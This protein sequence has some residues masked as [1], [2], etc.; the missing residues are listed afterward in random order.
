MI[1]MTVDSYSVL[2]T[3]SFREVR[4]IWVRKQKVLIGAAMATDLR[5]REHITGHRQQICY[6]N[7]LYLNYETPCI[8]FTYSGSSIYPT[9]F[10]FYF[11]KTCLGR[12]RREQD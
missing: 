10:Y 5:S 3:E 4:T 11:S 6:N 2:D 9:L 7:K 12:Q 8:A 1:M